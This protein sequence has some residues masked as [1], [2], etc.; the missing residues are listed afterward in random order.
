MANTL[1]ENIWFNLKYFRMV[2]L[3]CFAVNATIYN[4]INN[5]NTTFAL[6]EKF[7]LSI[8]VNF[9]DHSYI[10]EYLSMFLFAD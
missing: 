10:V 9:R 6:L 4:N 2:Y 1:T 5:K 7:L 3:T 8:E